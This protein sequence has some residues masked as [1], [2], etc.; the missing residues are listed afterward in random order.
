MFK[1]TPVCLFD[2]YF[3]YRAKLYVKKG[4][5]MLG[6][7]QRSQVDPHLIGNRCNRMQNEIGYV[8]PFF[9]LVHSA[10]SKLTVQCARMSKSQGQTQELY[11]VLMRKGLD[12]LTE[13]RQVG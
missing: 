1:L 2:C 12:A 5:P 9:L 11:S 13:S 7:I 8:V 4:K 10:G 6:R 3:R